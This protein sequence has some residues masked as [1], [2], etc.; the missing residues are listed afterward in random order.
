MIGLQDAR[1]IWSTVDRHHTKESPHMPRFLA[2]ILLVAVLA[3][4]GGI[5][6]TTA[7]Q[8]GVSTA[9][10]TTASG[11]AAV[12]TPVVV[13]AYGY[14]WGWGWHAGFGFFGFV[15]TLFFLFIVFALIRAIFWRGGP[16][17]RGGWGPGGWGGYDGSGKGP[18][19]PDQGAWET[20]NQAFEEWHRRAH[21]ET[22]PASPS[23]VAGPT[24]TA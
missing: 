19:G 5:I 14:G 7:Y 6:A 22:P 9:V 17:R 12:V 16:G 4:G 2:A 21:G 15:A 10:T 18:G 24:G 13:P 3:I 20:R 8:A 1:Q 11:S 23:D